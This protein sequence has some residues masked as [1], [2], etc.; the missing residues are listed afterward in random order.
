MTPL[1]A[2]RRRAAIA[3][4]IAAFVSFLL[5]SNEERVQSSRD[6]HTLRQIG[7]PDDV[8]AAALF[9]LGDQSRWI[10][11]QVWGVDGGLSTVRT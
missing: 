4:L 5:L 8:A 3:I 11:G 1:R 10:T 6:R 9:L 2:K 7:Q